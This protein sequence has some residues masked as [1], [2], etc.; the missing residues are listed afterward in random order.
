MIET[1]SEPDVTFV[2]I[3]QKTIS[4]ISSS[5]EAGQDLATSFAQHPKA[6]SVFYV[7]MI[8]VGETSGKLD[9]IFMQLAKYMERDKKTRNQIKS[10]LRYPMFVIAAIFI[11]I[12]VINIFVIPTFADLFEHYDTELPWATQVLLFTSNLIINHW[13]MLTG[14]FVGI[15]FW[16][17]YYVNTERGRYLWDKKKMKLPIVGRLNTQAENY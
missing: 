7:S 14:G 1:A 9:W 16:I 13:L 6:F 15:V 17:R 3:I 4:D 5:L 2:N 12:I 11:A 8:R 10:A